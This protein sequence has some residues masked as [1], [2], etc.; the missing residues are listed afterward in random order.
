MSLVGE[1]T[2]RVSC[3]SR[4]RG[5]CSMKM[6]K[7]VF[8]AGVLTVLGVAR[9]S[10]AAPDVAPDAT[11]S[12]P[13]GASAAAPAENSARPFEDREF[14]ADKKLSKLD[15]YINACSVTRKGPRESDPFF[16]Q[17]SR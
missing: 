4:S 12:G 2:D 8:V 1:A 3:C 15:E 17:L 16:K 6:L 9:V 14:G 13:E 10:F 11:H 5:V 7:W